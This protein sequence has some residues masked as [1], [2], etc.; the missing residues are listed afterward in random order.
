LDPRTGRFRSLEYLR[1]A[2]ATHG[3][4][5]DDEVVLYCDVGERSALA[6][7]VLSELLGRRGVRHYDG[8]WAEYGSLVGAPVT[9]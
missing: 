8:G 6:W 7:F 5:P 9:R 2:L 3:V 1:R 4:D